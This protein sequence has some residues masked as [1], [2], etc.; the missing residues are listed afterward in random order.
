M[1]TEQ[2][3][4]RIMD[5]N[6]LEDTIDLIELA[7]ALLGRWYFIV[8]AMLVFGGVMG[9]YNRYVEKPTYSAEAQVYISNTDSI[10]SLQEVQLSAALTQD[11]SSILTS[12]SVLKKVIANLGLDMDYRQMGKLISVTNPK[13]THILR[14][15]VTTDEPELSVAI[16]NSLIQIG[17]DRI[18]RIVGNETPSV[19]DYAEDDA[20]TINK[21][22]LIKHV[23]IGALAGMVLMCGLVVLHFLLDNTIKDEDDVHKLTHYNVLAEI[24]EYD[25][26]SDDLGGKKR[27]RHRHAGQAA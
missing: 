26:D 22:S 18:F 17:I 27:E 15:G 9:I 5:S 8:L 3:G 10:V 24:P 25:E 16:A 1:S 12:R 14:I 2:T 19:I 21:T 23:A 6:D 20:V 11:Y 13:D 4:K 7:K